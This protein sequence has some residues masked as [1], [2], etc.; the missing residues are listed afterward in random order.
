MSKLF[1]IHNLSFIILIVVPDRLELSTPTLSVLYS[2]QLSYETVAELITF[3]IN[4]HLIFYIDVRT[5]YLK[6][7]RIIS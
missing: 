3:V 6:I 7:R 4:R 5:E 1:I 2:N